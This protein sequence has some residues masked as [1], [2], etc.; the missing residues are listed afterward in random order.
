[1]TPEKKNFPEKSIDLLMKM[2]PTPAAGFFLICSGFGAL[3]PWYF[4]ALQI[5]TQESFTLKGLFEACFANFYTASI[6]SDLL[7]G[8]TA[9]MAWMIIEGNRLK[10]KRLWLYVV[11]AFMVSFAFSCP[12]FLYFRELKIKQLQP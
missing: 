3:I 7:I 11:L 5:A 12:L 1:L 2:I 8:S 4:N 10:M 9:V 6:S